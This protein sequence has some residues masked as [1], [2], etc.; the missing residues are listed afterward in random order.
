MNNR[1]RPNVLCEKVVVKE[2]INL[3]WNEIVPFFF[4]RL[5]KKGLGF[6]VFH[7]NFWSFILCTPSNVKFPWHYLIV[8][9]GN[10][11][12][13]VNTKT[14]HFFDN[15]IRGNGCCLMSLLENFGWNFKIVS[16]MHR[17][18]S[19]SYDNRP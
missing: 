2:V 18:W 8:N 13:M 19:T 14:S 3:I 9:Q 6:G 10:H 1:G 12:F 11:V 17:F 15:Q 16:I 5:V 4:T 7:R